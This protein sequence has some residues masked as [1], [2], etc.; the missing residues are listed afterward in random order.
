MCRKGAYVGRGHYGRKNSADFLQKVG[1]PQIAPGEKS[2]PLAQ[3][4]SDLHDTASNLRAKIGAIQDQ[5]GVAGGEQ[6]QLKNTEDQLHAQT[7]EM[8]ARVPADMQA[9]IAR[10]AAPDV[11]WDAASQANEANPTTHF[12]TAELGNAL[13]NQVIPPENQRA[14]R[15]WAR[16]RGVDPNVADLISNQ[17]LGAKAVKD[18]SS[19]LRGG[20]IDPTVAQTLKN[21]GLLHP[22]DPG[23]PNS[24]P[25]VTSDAKPLFPGT[26]QRAITAKPEAFRY[27]H[28]AQTPADALNLLARG[29]MQRMADTARRLLPKPAA[30]APGPMPEPGQRPAPFPAPPQREEMRVPEPRDASLGRTAEGFGGSKAP[31]PVAAGQ[32][33]AGEG[34]AGGGA[35]ERRA[36][37][38]EDRSANEPRTGPTNSDA[39]GGPND[40]T[41]K[42]EGVQGSPPITRGL[43]HP[44]DIAEREA[45]KASSNAQTPRNNEATEP[46]P[47]RKELGRIG[48]NL[49]ERPRRVLQGYLDGR[50]PEE[51]GAALDLTPEQSRNAYQVMANHAADL[52]RQRG[53]GEGDIRDALTPRPRTLGGEP[54]PPRDPI[55]PG[56]EHPLDI[57]DREQ[58]RLE[59]LRSKP[60]APTPAEIMR[61]RIVPH[62]ADLPKAIILGRLE[63]R[64]PEELSR[65]LGITP[66][67][68]DQG[69]H[70]IGR[71]IENTMIHRGIDPTAAREAMTP[72]SPRLA[73]SPEAS[74]YGKPAQPKPGDAAPGQMLKSAEAPPA[75]GLTPQQR[76]TMAEAHK[77]AAP[78]IFAD[79]KEQV[80]QWAK[81]FQ[82]LFSGFDVS[83]KSDNTGGLSYDRA[84]NRMKVSWNEVANSAGIT[85]QEALRSGASESEAR[86][87]AAGKVRSILD[88]ELRHVADV[89]ANGDASTKSLWHSLPPEI[90]DATRRVYA[91]D[92]P[93]SEIAGKSATQLGYEYKRILSQHDQTGE[94]SE[95]AEITKAAAEKAAQAVPHDR[96]GNGGWVRGVMDSLKRMANW[97][98]GNAGA[99]TARQLD[100]LHFEL[101]K[102][103][104]GEPLAPTDPS[105]LNS[106]SLG[107]PGYESDPAETLASSPAKSRSSTSR[108]RPE[109]TGSGNEEPS[110]EPNEK[111][112]SSLGDEKAQSALDK[113][114]RRYITYVLKDENNNVR[115]VGRA[116]G[117]GTPDEVMKGRIKRGH[118]IAKANLNLRPEVIDEQSSPDSNLGAEKL[119]YEYYKENGASL[120]NSPQSPPLSG[121]PS[122]RANTAQ[123]VR[124]YLNDTQNRTE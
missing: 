75:P 85:Y 48:D 30:A 120:L 76:D 59:A 122:K 83:D 26:M 82:K 60:S 58:R 77:A 11:D 22:S 94:V 61:E 49:V 53:F 98:R 43:E 108:Q 24:P 56:L 33:Q 32:G 63:G 8:L 88:E 74:Q 67:R 64:T 110:Q 79:A 6:D 3:S 23:D 119:W 123:R 18:L 35:G 90:Q 112:G 45:R 65:K 106:Q 19:A 92:N 17:A 124:E 105:D 70:A 96:D 103:T 113:V 37:I 84:S 101:E 111:P 9:R 42:D 117:F 62:I 40:G 55:I 7:R 68:A 93:T 34:I 15:Q 66:E 1:A 100:A 50:P 99:Q 10:A 12:A 41:G 116:S 121:K 44:L 118:K 46:S 25:N 97:L 115:Y 89:R 2:D 102:I 72:R 51:T 28:V 31:D 86:Q 38:G 13:R 47:A 14:M 69:G 57:A 54:P 52:L 36:G 114:T 71:Q 39:V 27:A 16:S 80:S 4:I 73:S 107:R 104:S 81:R 109:S 21:K 5:G 95:M 78:H 20:S 29:G 91:R 87:A